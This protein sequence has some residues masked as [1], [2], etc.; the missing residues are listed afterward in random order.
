MRDAFGDFVADAIIRVAERR[1]IGSKLSLH[2]ITTRDTTTR[3]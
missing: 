1:T 3:E 2:N